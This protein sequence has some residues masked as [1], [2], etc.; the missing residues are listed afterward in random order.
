MDPPPECGRTLP[1]RKESWMS[2]TMDLCRYYETDLNGDGILTC[3]MHAA[4]FSPCTN[5]TGSC[6]SSVSST[7]G[8]TNTSSVLSQMQRE[9]KGRRGATLKL[10]DT[11]TRIVAPIVS[12]SAR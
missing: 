6:A 2:R 8:V 12:H 10:G 5:L 1:L 11:A 9:L 7:L 4:R 3:A